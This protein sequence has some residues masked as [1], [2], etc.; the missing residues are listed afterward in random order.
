MIGSNVECQRLAL[1]NFFSSSVNQ[2]EGLPISLKIRN[3]AVLAKYDWTVNPSNKLSVS[4]NFDRSNNTNQ[5]FDVPTYGGSAN[6]IEGPSKIHSINF[7]MFT[8]VGPKKVNEAHYS[9]GRE[10]R[11]RSA[12]S[13]NVPAD[14]A[15]G[16]AT[17]FRFGAPFFLE[18]KVDETFKRHQVRDS[19]SILAGKHTVKF[20]GEWL[21]SEN[22]QVFRGFFTDRYIFDSV[23]GFLH[24]ASPAS[25][26]PG[27]GPATAECAN[28]TFVTGVGSACSGG[29][30][31]TSSPLLLYLQGAG[32]SGPATDA[33][34]VRSSG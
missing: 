14:T 7:N 29:G 4:Y 17:T 30:F 10:D 32:L 12:V 33:A 19:F 11:P 34:R 25:L 22:A 6:G 20:G 31:A 16:F 28:G 9:F 3:T 1:L 27:Y 13:S 24:Y 18:P 26:G 15:M 21:H 23:L 5:T 8:T 2:K